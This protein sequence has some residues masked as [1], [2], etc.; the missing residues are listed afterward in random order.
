VRK[1]EE[2]EAQKAA[3]AAPE[4]AQ[5][6]EE[7]AG[8]A[9]PEVKRGRGGILKALLERLNPLRFAREPAPAPGEGI[10]VESLS[11]AVRGRELARYSVGPAEVFV[12][13]DGRTGYY[14]VSEPGLSERER[15]VLR[16]LFDYFIYVIEP[17]AVEAEDPT[18]Y[19]EGAIWRAAEELGLLE[20]VRRGFAKYRYFIERDGL[21]YGKL[22][23][24]MMDPEV[25]EITVVRY[26]EPARVIHRKFTGLDW[27]VTNIVFHSEAELGEFNQ[28][29]AQRLG[30]TL[31]AAVPM[32]DATTLT[33]DRVSMTFG[34]EISH[35]G[36]TLTIRKFPREPFT[37]AYLVGSNTLSPL[38]AAYLWQ[39]LE[40]RG[41]V[42]VLGG[43]GSGKTTLLGSLLASINP[44]RKIITVEDTL[45]LN[46]P[47]GNWQRFHTRSVHFAM[48]ERFEVD[49]QD[50]VKLVMRHRPDY[51]AIGEAR[52]E[53]IKTLTHAAAL[54]HSAASTFHADSPEAALARMRA[55][56]LTDDDILRIWCF[57][58]V[59][60]IRKPSGEVAHRVL[61]IHELVPAEGGKPKV[62]CLFR[63]SPRADSF[64]PGS[65]PELVRRSRRLREA[66][67][68]RGLS[69]RELVGVIQ[70][71]ADFLRRLVRR[72]ELG[73]RQYTDRVREFYAQGGEL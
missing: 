55:L 17:E 66:A 44:N 61:G 23:V 13:F 60:R 56:G 30:K 71:K 63:Y 50:L 32:V 15:E 4:E 64:S 34:D 2:P 29:L 51:V 41:F 46:L 8:G 73:F 25:E 33:G 3:G 48:S 28:R 6:A 31:T 16:N 54:G 49:L 14:E 5:K 43:V 38:M 19:V 59:G 62:V 7:T 40:Y 37:L 45:E 27:L 70:R 20:E 39:V 35:P 22:H 1:K 24:P 47:H 9:P 53:E 10:A 65:A 52:G 72:R 58:V 36:S 26:G 68:A 18:R 21:G 67:W 42:Q 12:F 57:A 11:A 69:D